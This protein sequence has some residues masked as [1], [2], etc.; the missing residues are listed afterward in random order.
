M[1]TYKDI[2]HKYIDFEGA[3]LS[4][5]NQTLLFQKPRIFN[6]PFDCYSRLLELKEPQSYINHLIETFHSNWSVA[7]RRKEKSKMMSNFNKHGLHQVYDIERERI[8]VA[9]FSKANNIS[10]MWAYYCKSHTGITIGYEIPLGIFPF[11]NSKFPAFLFVVEYIKEI[12]K[13]QMTLGNWEYIYKWIITKSFEWE[14]EKEVRLIHLHDF[15]TDERQFINHD[16]RMVKKNY[17]WCKHIS[18]GY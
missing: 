9:S 13:I 15:S 18:G 14:H 10:L 1:E 8:S 17:F 3:K 4:L 11:E 7:K 12:E 16:P 5:K 6:D 2:I